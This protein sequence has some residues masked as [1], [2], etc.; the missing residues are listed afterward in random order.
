MRQ[1]IPLPSK[2]QG[3]TLA[4]LKRQQDTALIADGQVV[5]C[6]YGHAYGRSILVEPL[7][8]AKGAAGTTTAAIA[9]PS[10]RRQGDQDPMLHLQAVAHAPLALY[11]KL[12]VEY[13]Q[14]VLSIDITMMDRSTDVQ[15]QRPMTREEGRLT[16]DLA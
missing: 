5:I 9:E 12:N 1:P 2:L 4:G 10:R 7:D 8:Q 3:A 15:G 14:F 6:S 11:R 13:D 16:D